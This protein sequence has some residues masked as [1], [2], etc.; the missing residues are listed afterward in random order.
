MNKGIPFLKDADFELVITEASLT[1]T[2]KEI[3]YFGL[4]E[5][6]SRIPYLQQSPT[7]IMKLIEYNPE[8]SPSDRR[9][10]IQE[11]KGMIQS[12]QEQAKREQDI[13]AASIVQDGISSELQARVALQSQNN[14]TNNAR[15]E[16]AS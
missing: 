3:K 9:M 2:E 11:I 7:F 16:Q 8:I 6:A 14:R 1:E 10:I 4:V 12:Q 5:A 15:R 13:K